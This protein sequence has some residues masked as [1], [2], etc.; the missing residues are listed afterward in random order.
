[1]PGSPCA[2]SILEV[3]GRLEETAGAGPIGIGVPGL[4]R[5]GR[6]LVFGPHLR[7]AQGADLVALLEPSLGERRILVRNDADLAAI[8]EHE[9]GADYPQRP[10]LGAGPLLPCGPARGAADRFDGEANG[11]AHVAFTNPDGTTAVVLANRGAATQVSLRVGGREARVA[12]EAN[13]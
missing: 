5:D 10:I 6:R 8:A 9:A 13:R 4:V 7:S 12:V 3:V 1:M 11:V 2:A